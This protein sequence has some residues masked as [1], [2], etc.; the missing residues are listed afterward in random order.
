MIQRLQREIGRLQHLAHESRLTHGNAKV[1]EPNGLHA[2]HGNGD[3]LGVGFRR[4]QSNQFDSRLIQFLHV[5][6]LGSTIAKH[7][8]YVTKAQRTRFILETGGRQFGNLRGDIRTQGDH[9]PGMALFKFKQA[10]V[11]CLAQA[12]GERVKIL[13]CRRHHFLE[14]PTQKHVEQEVLQ[15]AALGCHQRWQGTRTSGNF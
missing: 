8:G 15:F 9:A 2:L 6:G 1:I 3:H 7:I 10:L 4:F 11:E 13:K 5:A 12:E 14:A